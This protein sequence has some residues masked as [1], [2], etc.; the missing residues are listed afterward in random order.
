MRVRNAGANPRQSGVLICGTAGTLYEQYCMTLFY[1][2]S[3]SGSFRSGDSYRQGEAIGVSTD[4]NLMYNCA[5]LNHLHFELYKIDK[6]CSP[7]ASV[8]VSGCRWIDFVWGSS[9]QGA[10]VRTVDPAAY[11]CSSHVRSTCGA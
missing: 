4:V 10:W 1:V 5:M 11:M 6:R 7:G 2:R 3:T 9:T 8:T